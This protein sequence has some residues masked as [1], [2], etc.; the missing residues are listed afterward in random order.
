MIKAKHRFF[1][2]LAGEIS[3]AAGSSI[4][5]PRVARF[6]QGFTPS[7]LPH[8]KQWIESLGYLWATAFKSLS[9]C[10]LP[11]SQRCLVGFTGASSSHMIIHF[12]V[13][14][15][16]EVLHVHLAAIFL[17][18]LELLLQCL[19]FAVCAKS[20]LPPRCLL[21]G[22]GLGVS[23]LVIFLC[24]CLGGSF[25]VLW[26]L[27]H[28]LGALLLAHMRNLTVRFDQGLVCSFGSHVLCQLKKTCG[29]LVQELSCRI[30]LGA[31]KLK[32]QK[33]KIAR[34]KSHINKMVEND[35]LLAKTP[36]SAENCWHLDGV[37]QKAR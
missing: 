6:C 28:S 11:K 19:V 27:C 17:V 20:C 21:L 37:F 32:M 23:H 12:M 29:L 35:Y 5:L 22:L 36:K 4:T 16:S 15:R 26:L 13:N 25:L 31:L 9:M 18:H 1:P 8:A 33:V 3:P 2:V 10:L 24:H 14:A 30:I 7:L 34:K